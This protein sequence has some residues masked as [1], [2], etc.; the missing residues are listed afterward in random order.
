VIHGQIT[1]KKAGLTMSVSYRHAK[2]LKRC[3]V[4]KGANRLIHVNRDQPS[5]ALGIVQLPKRY[6]NLKRTV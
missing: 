1:L 6:R 5:W 2:G 4:M 3:L